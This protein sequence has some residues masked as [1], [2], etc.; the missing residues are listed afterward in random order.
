MSAQ[1][2]GQ[3]S[4]PWQGKVP[5][6]ACVFINM[7]CFVSATGAKGN[8]LDKLTDEAKDVM[9]T[10]DS[11]LTSVTDDIHSG[12]VLIKHLEEVFQHQEQFLCIWDTSKRV[13][14]GHGWL[15]AS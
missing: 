3:G 12:R 8:L 13:Q 4:V 5:A 14:R 1:A 15:R 2:P 6:S 9:A 7:M 11:V 10:A